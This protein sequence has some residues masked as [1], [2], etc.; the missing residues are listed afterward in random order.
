MPFSTTCRM[1]RRASGRRGTDLH[2]VAGEAMRSVDA[3]PMLTP[4][5]ILRF[6]S[7]REEELQ[8]GAQVH[9]LETSRRSRLESP[10]TLLGD[11]Q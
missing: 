5:G 2:A 9:V 11:R 10:E 6:V 8:V 3:A 4:F 1:K 7:S